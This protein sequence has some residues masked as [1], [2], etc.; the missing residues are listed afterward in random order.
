MVH[1]ETDL[2]VF[3]VASCEFVHLNV[4]RSRLSLDHFLPFVELSKLL[5]VL[6]IMVTQLLLSCVKALFG[7]LEIDYRKRSNQ[8]KLN[9]RL[10]FMVRIL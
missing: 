7:R 5:L 3:W 2:S 1:E 9:E 4:C 8:S 10:C 6:Y